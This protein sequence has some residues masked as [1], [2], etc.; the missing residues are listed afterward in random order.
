MTLWAGI[1]AAFGTLGMVVAGLFAARATA[2]AATATAEATRA[3]AQAAAEPNQRA[4]DRAAFDAIKTELRQELTTTR[5][6]VRSLRSLVR[7]FA[8]YV[9]EL[10]TQMRSQG[11]EPPAPPDRIDEYNR[12][13][14]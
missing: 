10:T 2:R 7:S 6:D 4:E 13:G 1:V 5:D 14:V 12:T 8:W 3:A 9:A 11:I